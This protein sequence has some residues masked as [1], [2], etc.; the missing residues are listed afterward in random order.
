MEEELTPT[1]K[2]TPSQ[3]LR[4]T[5]Y[6]VWEQKKMKQEFEEFYKDYI[7]K[8]IAYLKEDYLK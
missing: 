6:R 5:L 8:I 7:E 2:R 4:W 1:K 3:H